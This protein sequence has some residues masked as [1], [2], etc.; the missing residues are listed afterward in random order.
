MLSN[1]DCLPPELEQFVITREIVAAWMLKTQMRDTLWGRSY[2]FREGRD[3]VDAS[4]WFLTK[5]EQFYDWL[6]ESPG[7]LG[8]GDTAQ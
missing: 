1:K 3:I 6:A 4:Q 2:N 8:S 5:M 7:E